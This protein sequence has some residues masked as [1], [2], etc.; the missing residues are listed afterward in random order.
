MS[1]QEAVAT[2]EAD[3]NVVPLSE[4]ELKALTADLQAVLAKHNAEMGV[5]STINLMKVIIN[6]PSGNKENNTKEEAKEKPT[7]ADTKTE[8]SS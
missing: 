6:E 1:D 2:P 5:T 7:E 4:E 8:T 3:V